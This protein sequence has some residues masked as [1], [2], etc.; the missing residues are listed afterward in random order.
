M[1]LADDRVERERAYHN[2]RFR[3]ESRLAQGKYY[4]AI[5]D[6]AEVFTN[7]VIEKATGADALEYGC[8]NASQALTLAPLARSICGIDISD[9]A[10][11]DAREAAKGQANARFEVMNAEAL[12]FP[13]ASFDLVFGR[14]IVHHLDLTK[15]F[16]EVARVLRP[17]GTALFWEPLGHNLLLN[18]YRSLTPNAR[19]PDEHPL[20]AADFDLARQ[21]FGDVRTRFYGLTSLAAVPFGDGAVGDAVLKVSAGIDRA[22]FRV[23]GLKWQAWY[24]MIELSAPRAV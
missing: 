11:L 21:Y 3:D 6:G 4:R 15:C 2:E 13:D 9:V 22:L 16:G 20:L 12:E 23:P 17:G 10:I 24:C 5:R 19:T 8:G 7:R 18:G 14:G 1:S